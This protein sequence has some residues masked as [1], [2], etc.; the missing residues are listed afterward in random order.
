MSTAIDIASNAL[1]LIG[2]EPISSFDESGAGAKATANLYEQTRDTLLAEHPW[3]FAMK[4]QRLNL[5][6]QEVDSLR[7]YKYAFQI[8]TD[9]IRLW[10]L[11]PVGQNY[12]IQ[13]NILYCNQKELLANYVFSVNESKFPPHFVKALE[14]RL[15]SEIAISV[16]EDVSVSEVILSKYIAQIV[17]AKNIDSQGKPQ[18]SIIDQPFVQARLGGYGTGFGVY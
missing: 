13:E 10:S 9:L 2:D 18:V 12:E 15:A 16:T 5:L 6:S 11:Y 3:T 17:R 14:Y 4:S 7:Y 8:P 1:I